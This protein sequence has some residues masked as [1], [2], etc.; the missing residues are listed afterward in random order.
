M[1]WALVNMVVAM[2]EVQQTV[3]AGG[4]AFVEMAPVRTPFLVPAVS[5]A[6]VVQAFVVAFVES[7]GLGSVGFGSVDSVGVGD[8]RPSRSC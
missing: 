8:N 4:A 7:V 2:A 6:C 3:E 5:F 1:E